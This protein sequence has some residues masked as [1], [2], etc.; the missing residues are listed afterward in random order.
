MSAQDSR[1]CL[2]GHVATSRAMECLACSLDQR[3]TW[4]QGIRPR[5]AWR[6]EHAG[7][8]MQPG[9]LAPPPARPGRERDGR[10]STLCQLRHLMHSL[11]AW[12]ASA[13]G[14]P[15]A[16]WAALG[17]IT[18]SQTSE[19]PARVVVGVA[20]RLAARACGAEASGQLRGEARASGPQMELAGCNSRQ[21]AGARWRAGQ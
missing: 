3:Q 5:Q 1:L 16:A 12:Q 19:V 20:P 10:P 7:R 14:L 17:V 6:L 2:H 9:P 4:H 11:P 15:T 21:R 13:W 8:G 18:S